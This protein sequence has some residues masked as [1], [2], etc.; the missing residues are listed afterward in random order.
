MAIADVAR[1][2]DRVEPGQVNTHEAVWATPI[3]HP[4]IFLPEA[5]LAD[6]GFKSD[7]FRQLFFGGKRQHLARYRLRSDSPA[8]KLGF[9]PIPVEKI[10]PYA[11]PLRASWPIVEAEGVRETPVIGRTSSQASK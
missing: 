3:H 2:S 7:G 6:Q 10:G 5:N 1:R 9:Q 11:D 4:A 8:L